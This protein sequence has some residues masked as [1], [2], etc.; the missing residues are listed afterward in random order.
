MVLQQFKRV[1]EIA[2]KELV[3]FLTPNVTEQNTPSQMKLVDTE[4]RDGL[5]KHWHLI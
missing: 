1:L 4:V 2:N 5:T 3:S